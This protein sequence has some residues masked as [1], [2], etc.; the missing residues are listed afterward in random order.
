MAHPKEKLGR[1]ALD[2]PERADF[3]PVLSHYSDSM[4]QMGTYRYTGGKTQ[5]S[6]GEGSYLAE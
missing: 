3:G 4:R 1:Q 5:Q 6:T 2:R